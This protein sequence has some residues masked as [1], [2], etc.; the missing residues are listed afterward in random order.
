[1]FP[2]CLEIDRKIHE[3]LD[4]ESSDAEFNVSIKKLM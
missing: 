4:V 3:N 2:S 1:M